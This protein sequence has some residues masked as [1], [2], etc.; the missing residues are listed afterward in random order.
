MKQLLFFLLVYSLHANIPIPK[1]TE[2]LLVVQANS[3][4]TTTASLQAYTRNGN[5]WTKV[6]K[7]IRVN[8]GRHGLGW[9]EGEIDLK[10]K[11]EEPLKFEGDGKAPAGLFSLDGFFG[12]EKRNFNFPYLHLTTQDICVDDSSS[13]DYNQLI[14]T[15]ETKKYKSFE[16]MRRKDNLYELG[17]LVG[18]NKKGLKKR[19]SCIFIH[20]Q[21]NEDSPTS[22]CT[23]MRKE[24]LLK[25]MKWLDH[26]KKPLL[27]QLPMKSSFH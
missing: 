11:E 23:S 5:T 3:F 21:R 6:F 14:R 7:P 17:I 15:K 25:L 24:E 16:T 8:L 22:G 4:D 18:H 12:Y 2:Q 1:Q 20:I 9:G 10:Q 27:L 19:G 13:R 26:A